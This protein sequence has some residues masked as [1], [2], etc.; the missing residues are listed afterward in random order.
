VNAVAGIAVLVLGFGIYGLGWVNVSTNLLSL[1]GFSFFLWVQRPLFG[2]YG[3]PNPLAMLRSSTPYLFSMLILTAYS[4]IDVL[5]MTPLLET[6]AIGWYSVAM[7]LYG[8]LL[9]LP[10]IMST[11]IFPAM[12]RSHGNGGDGKPLLFSKSFDLLM[13]IAVPLGLGL[14][15]VSENVIG[16]LYGPAFA[17]SALVLALMGIVLIFMYQNILMGQFLISVDRQNSWTAV[18]VAGLVLTIGLD[19]VLVHWFQ[20]TIG[21]GAVGGAVSYVISEMLM[22]IAGL[23]LLPRSLLGRRNAA[24]AG[25]ILLA[26]GLMTVSCWWARDLFIAVPVLI[27]AV[28]YTAAILALRVVPADDQ[29]IIVGY[30][31]GIGGRLQSRLRSVVSRSAS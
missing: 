14:A 2:S 8:T 21:N 5:I 9:F 23:F 27:G 31:S 16:L 12:A 22:F 25:R 19:I 7:T 29:A 20:R 24:T 3:T 11:A 26:G 6:A 18:M 10:S 17:P 1:L 28:V 4:H 15:I 30:L 13:L